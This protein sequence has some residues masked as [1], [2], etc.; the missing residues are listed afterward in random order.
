MAG[1]PFP[2]LSTVPALS[3]AL[4]C[5]PSGSSCHPISPPHIVRPFNRTHTQLIIAVDSR[6]NSTGE[7]EPVGH[8]VYHLFR[9]FVSSV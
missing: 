3:V 8:H 6:M 4:R 9:S 7:E 1:S 5:H 2:S